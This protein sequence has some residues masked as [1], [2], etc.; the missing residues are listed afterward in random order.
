MD[1][2]YPKNEQDCSVVYK[3]ER[4]GP[5]MFRVFYKNQACYRHT[6]KEV[7]ACFGVAR[8]TPSVNE[9]REWC[10]QMVKEYGSKEDKADENYLKYIEKHGFGPEVHGLDKDQDDDETDGT[11]D[12]KMI[13]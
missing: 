5:N 7:G 13:T 1:Y 3:R 11:K 6:P 12:T 10:Y 8:F 9:I 4:T 2:P